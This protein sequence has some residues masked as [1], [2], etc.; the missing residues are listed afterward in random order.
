MTKYIATKLHKALELAPDDAFLERCSLTP[1]YVID[2]SLL[3]LLQRSDVTASIQAML[4]AA[5][6]H[7]PYPELVIEL[8]LGVIR[9][10][11]FLEED[12]ERFRAQLGVL[13]S[14][15]AAFEVGPFLNITPTATGLNITA[16][17][18]THVAHGRIAALATGIALLMLNIKG[19]EKEELEASRLNKHR[20]ARGL[21]GIPDH[22]LVR[23][24][25]AYDISGREHK[26]GGES[27]RTMPIHL[28]Q[29]HARR[30]H[31][32][33]GNAET[34]VIY[35]PPVIVNFYPG[36]TLPVPRKVIA[37]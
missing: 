37:A 5:I 2:K 14:S 27:G 7:L 12:G 21:P 30:Q 10:F 17:E 11:V 33:E 8:E 4:E 23:I 34:K 24:A 35:V 13:H 36:A 3:E 9:A 15:G 26:L 16:E 28:R 6:C 32:G 25:H 31:F 22:A 1:S 20:E 29:G 19:V 18:E